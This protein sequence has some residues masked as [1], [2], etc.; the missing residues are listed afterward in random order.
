MQAKLV[1]LT[2]EHIN[3]VKQSIKWSLWTTNMQLNFNL[4]FEI[5]KYEIWARNPWHM[6]VNQ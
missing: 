5:W 1:K 4:E 3:Q 6:V 2:F